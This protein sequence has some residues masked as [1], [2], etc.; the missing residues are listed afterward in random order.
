MAYQSGRIVKCLVIYLSYPIVA[1]QIDTGRR[2][3]IDIDRHSLVWSG[4]C[5]N[6]LVRLRDRRT[7]TDRHLNL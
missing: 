2:V 4:L 6:G 1:V 7:G 5:C 3:P